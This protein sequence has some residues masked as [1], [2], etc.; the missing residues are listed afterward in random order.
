[1]GIR[2]RVAWRLPRRST[3]ARLGWAGALALAMVHG[4]HAQ[5]VE[6]YPCGADD[7][8]AGLGAGAAWGVA[9]SDTLRGL[10]VFVKF[11]DEDVLAPDCDPTSWP[12]SATTVPSW[13]NTLLE[14]YDSGNSPLPPGWAPQ[15]EGSLTHFFYRMSG[16]KHVLLGETYPLVVEADHT[17]AHYHSTYTWY[18]NASGNANKD[19]LNQLTAAGVDWRK[20]NYDKYGQADDR[21]VDFV[22]MYYREF[23]DT[24][25]THF[26]N[27]YFDGAIRYISGYSSLLPQDMVVGY[28][29]GDMLDLLGGRHDELRQAGAVRRADRDTNPESLA[30]PGDRG[31]RVRPRSRGAGRVRHLPPL[32]GRALRHHGRHVPSGTG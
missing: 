16:G 2:T 29:D 31:T 25:R 11:S 1:M 20:Y 15:V 8:G 21:V 12:H 4:V 7:G 26:M 27:Q 14:D 28:P 30:V 9:A 3:A 32:V 24:T 22:F 5:D 13:A 6:E 10:V 23:M 19:I 18:G 17:I